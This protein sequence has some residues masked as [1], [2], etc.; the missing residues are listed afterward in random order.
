[1][2]CPLPLP[3]TIT[4]WWET[5]RS[6]VGFNVL[7]HVRKTQANA[8]HRRTAFV[9]IIVNEIVD[10]VFCWLP[11]MSL[12]QRRPVATNLAFQTQDVLAQS[13]EQRDAL[14]FQNEHSDDV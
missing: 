8:F 3:S 14:S 12:Q 11:R 10:E 13:F 4:R 6:T 1:M 9:Q 2:K 5:L 7:E